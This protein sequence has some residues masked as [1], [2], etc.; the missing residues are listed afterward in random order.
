MLNIDKYAYASKLKHKDPIEKLTF[1]LTTLSICLWAHSVSVSILI[2]IMMTAV[3]VLKGKI[4]F[5]TVLKLMLIPMSF[6][7][8]G[9]MTIAFEAGLDKR[10]FIFSVSL[11]NRYIGLTK[12]GALEATVIFF[13]AL[14]AVACL[15]YLSVNTPMVDLLSALK[16]LKC[17]KLMVELMSL[18]YRFIFVLTETAAKMFAA[19]NSR[20]GYDRI[21]SGDRS[22]GMLL[23]TLFIRSYK[24][25]DEIYTALE[26]RG[27]EG[28]IDMLEEPFEK[29]FEGYAFIVVI[30][31]LL[32]TYTLYI[33]HSTG[34]LL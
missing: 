32:I 22:M 10:V 26:A 20:L 30:N 18:I 6:L 34:G 5:N 14:G 3:T 21:S 19:Q 9:V 7:I 27:Y 33:R 11:F 16:K 23:S 17:P 25:S 29:S 28:D 31:V 12:T 13:R 4:P 8:L 2:L 24:K 15:Y 1:S